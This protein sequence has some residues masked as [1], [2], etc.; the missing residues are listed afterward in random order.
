[1]SESVLIALIS[2][3]VDIIRLWITKSVTGKDINT[4]MA[5]AREDLQRRAKTAGEAA[6]KYKDEKKN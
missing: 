1:M 6:A 5:N 4:V 2:A 3:G